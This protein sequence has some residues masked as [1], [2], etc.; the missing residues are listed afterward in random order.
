MKHSMMTEIPF[1][2]KDIYLNVF[3]LVGEWAGG[4]GGGGDSQGC[5]FIQRHFNAP[6]PLLEQLH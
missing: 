3:C 6:N 2:Q 1:S 5:I 4:G